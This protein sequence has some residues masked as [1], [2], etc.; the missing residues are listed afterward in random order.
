MFLIRITCYFSPNIGSIITD[1]THTYAITHLKLGTK[2]P[3][4][5]TAAN[6]CLISSN[7]F[8]VLFVLTFVVVKKNKRLDDINSLHFS[9]QI[10]DDTFTDKMKIDY[11]FYPF[12]L[13]SNDDFDEY[14]NS[15]N[16]QVS[17]KIWKKA[18]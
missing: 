8:L 11:V 4:S 1:R 12:R 16:I 5:S 7:L 6:N 9:N 13:T 15:N 2:R 18:I 17:I 10:N 14:D 3:S